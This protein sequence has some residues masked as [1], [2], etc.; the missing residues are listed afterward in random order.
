MKVF[1]GFPLISPT[2]DSENPDNFHQEC[3]GPKPYLRATGLIYRV[4]NK[5]Q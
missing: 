4:F 3:A 1:L 2:T 5:K